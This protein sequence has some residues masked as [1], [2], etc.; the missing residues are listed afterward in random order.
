VGQEHWTILVP[1]PSGSS[2]SVHVRLTCS[3]RTSRRQSDHALLKPCLKS[4]CSRSMLPCHNWQGH[5]VRDNNEHGTTSAATTKTS[6]GHRQPIHI[7]RGAFT[8][9]PTTHP[10]LVMAMLSFCKQRDKAVWVSSRA[11][12]R[13]DNVT[14]RV[15]RAKHTRGGRQ[16]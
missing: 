14:D 10:V 7:V 5:P 15:A 4:N 6:R 11:H 1:W 2:C 8:A 13:S 12:G 16:G 9:T 3:W